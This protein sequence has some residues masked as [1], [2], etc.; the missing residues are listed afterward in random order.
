[1]KFCGLLG[2]SAGKIEFKLFLLV[3][4]VA[5][6]GTGGQ[7]RAREQGKQKKGN[8]RTLSFESCESPHWSLATCF[9]TIETQ[10]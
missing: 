1:M 2:Y 5:F 8:E 6:G 7:E 9:L 4:R 3:V 10:H